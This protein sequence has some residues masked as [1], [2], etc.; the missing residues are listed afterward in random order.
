MRIR[1]IVLLGALVLG[2][3][4]CQEMDV[5][6]PNNPGRDNVLKSGPDVQSLISTAFREWFERTEGTSPGISLSFMADEFTGGFFDF[7]GQE[8]SREPRE[9]LNQNS[10]TNP[11]PGTWTLYYRLIAGINTAFRAIEEN[12]LKII[13]GGADVTVRANA[14]GKFVQGLSHGQIALQFDQGYVSSEVTDFGTLSFEEARA[15]LRPYAE[16]RDTALAQLKAAL[17]LAQANTFSLPG[18]G[19]EWVSGVD[20]TNQDLARLIN[21][22]IARLM[23]YTARNPT[24][25]AAVNWN[26]VI[27]RIDAGITSDFAPVAIPGIMESIFKHR[28]GRQRTTTPGDFMRVDYMVVGPADQGQGWV[29]WV[30]LPWSNRLPF[31]MTN[32]ADRRI[33]GLPAAQRPATCSVQ[34]TSCGLYM[35]YHVSNVWNADRGTGQRSYYIYHRMGTG[36]AWQLGPIVIINRAELDMLKAE[37]LIRLG[38]AAEAIPLINKTRVANGQLAPVD[39]N[40]APGTAPNCTPRKFNGSCGSLWDALRYE[41]RI[42]T[43]GLEGGP[44]FYDARGWQ[45]LVQNTLLHFPMPVTDLE[46][47]AMPIYTTGGGQAGSAPAPAV[48]KCPVALPR[49]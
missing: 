8:L 29:N 3:S 46:L 26:E 13:E 15:L 20:M 40:G 7:G 19:S 27:T 48:E 38:R 42:E 24:E 2:A 6:N 18:A 28:A 44:A 32:L 14:F 22:Y 10:G 34:T 23:V 35:G 45:G 36:T 39:I 33:D 12:D 41:K 49:C 47:L 30:A 16:V 1:T 31:R 4:A 5:T 17:A 25:R 9:P 21:T 37:G 43:L 11:A